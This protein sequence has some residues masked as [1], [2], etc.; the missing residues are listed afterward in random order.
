MKFLQNLMMAWRIA[1]KEIK[2][3][4]AYD[5][6]EAWTEDDRKALRSFVASEAG[7]KLMTR[8]TNMTMKSAVSAT[9]SPKDTKYNFGIARGVALAINA[10]Q[11]HFIASP[12]VRNT[13]SSVM[14]Q[15]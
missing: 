4:P 8:L 7:T 2:F 13:R 14:K 12:S 10:L 3:A 6:A 9:Q 1:T 15:P 5:T 11:E